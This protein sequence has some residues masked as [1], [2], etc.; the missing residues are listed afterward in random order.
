MHLLLKFNMVINLHVCANLTIIM[1]I[2]DTAVVPIALVEHV[3]VT[4]T[5]TIET[6]ELH[7]FA[8]TAC[9]ATSFCRNAISPHQTILIGLRAGSLPLAGKPIRGR[10]LPHMKCFFSFFGYFYFY[11]HL[12]NII[13]NSIDSFRS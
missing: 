13:I 10:N 3:L 9:S 7:D 12:I 4:M 6:E 5:R 2:D 11:F 1:V 8:R